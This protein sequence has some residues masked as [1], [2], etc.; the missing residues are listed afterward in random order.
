VTVLLALPLLAVDKIGTELQYPFSPDSL[1]HLPLDE[2]CA[3]IEGNLLAMLE[4]PS[5]S[6][7]PA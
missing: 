4:Q 3:T 1:N 5:T 6:G 2:I 7:P